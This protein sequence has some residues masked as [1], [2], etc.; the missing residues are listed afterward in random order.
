MNHRIQPE[1]VCWF[2]IPSKYVW[3]LLY[4]K[5]KHGIVVMF[6]NWMRFTTGTPDC[7]IGP[8]DWYVSGGWWLGHIGICSAWWEKKGNIYVCAS[9]GW[10]TK[11][12]ILGIVHN[13]KQY[14]TMHWSAWWWNNLVGGLDHFSCFHILRISPSQL[15]NSFFQGSWN[16]QP[17]V[18]CGA[19]KIAKWVYN[20]SN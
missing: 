15:T 3:L 19:P 9:S 18:Q 11:L 14:K 20:Y 2:W 5:P 8:L 17:Y 7:M 12:H 13:I 10:W 6:K 4:H 16:H 1:T